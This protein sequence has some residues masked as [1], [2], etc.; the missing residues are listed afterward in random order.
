MIVHT[1]KN[2]KILQNETFKALCVTFEDRLNQLKTTQLTFTQVFPVHSISRFVRVE[3]ICLSVS[4][5]HILFSCV[6]CR[7]Q[8]YKRL[9]R[10]G[11]K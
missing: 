10:M 11:E 5:M 1:S 7:I 2:D 3:K 8:N 6:T 9:S 4:E